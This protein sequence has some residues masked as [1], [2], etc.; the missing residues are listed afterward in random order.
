MKTPA[1]WL[2][3]KL[4]TDESQTERKHLAMKPLVINCNA[5]IHADQG[6]AQY[7]APTAYTVCGLLYIKYKKHTYIHIAFTY[8][9]CKCHY[10]FGNSSKA[11]L[12]ILMTVLLL[13]QN[14]ACAY[15]APHQ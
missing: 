10:V 4:Y 8:I 12:C 14:T 15:L 3:V 1:I 9:T 2:S 13:H 6:E 5:A 11:E 7:T